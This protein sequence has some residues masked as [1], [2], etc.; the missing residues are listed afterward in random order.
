MIDQSSFEFEKY[1]K[2]LYGI[3]KEFI[4][5]LFMPKD[6]N[7]QNKV[8]DLTV[9]ENKFIYYPFVYPEK[10]P[11]IFL[12]QKIKK[13]KKGNEEAGISAVSL[14]PEQMV[15]KNGVLNLKFIS[16]V[17]VMDAYAPI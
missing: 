1:D 14:S 8:M 17:M 13:K 6:S 7:F 10:V 9:D 15:S 4:L 5:D 16:F 3:D 11:I 2:K 12:N